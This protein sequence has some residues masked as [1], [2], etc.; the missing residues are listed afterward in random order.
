[1][2]IGGISGPELLTSF[3]FAARIPSYGASRCRHNPREHKQVDLRRAAA[4]QRAR[5]RIG[6]RARGQDIV[7][8]HDFAP[9][10]PG[11]R[12]R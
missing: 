1:M 8:E 9:L 10:Q 3:K 6:G 7:D 4:Q 5:R 12:F 11:L 2:T